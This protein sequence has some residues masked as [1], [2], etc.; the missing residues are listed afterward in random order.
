[1]PPAST[2]TVHV[3]DTDCLGDVIGV[4]RELVLTCHCARQRVVGLAA[5]TL[6]P[7]IGARL[8]VGAFR[9]RMR[10]VICGSA[11]TAGQVELRYWRSL[12]H[13]NGL[14]A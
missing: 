9:Q 12:A 3:S 1:M 6:V 10:C 13:T 11:G 14:E 2:A 8:T 4:E 5:L 7:G